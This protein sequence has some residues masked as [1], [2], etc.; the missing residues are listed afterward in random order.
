MNSYTTNAA[1]LILFTLAFPFVAAGQTNDSKWVVV[2]ND[3]LYVTYLDENNIFEDGGL[4]FA[5]NLFYKK[6]GTFPQPPNTKYSI[7]LT[8]YDCV[9]LSFKSVQAIAYSINGNVIVSADLAGR[10]MQR[11]IPGTNGA[12]QVKRVCEETIDE[13]R[14]VSG[15][16]SRQLAVAD[17]RLKSTGLSSKRKGKKR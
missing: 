12:L 11:P 8:A 5:Y 3:D 1:I 15:F 4:K 10:E 9:S 13:N 17:A 14:V 6:N 7:Y 2:K 16:G